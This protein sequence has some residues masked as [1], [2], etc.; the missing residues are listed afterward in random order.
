MFVRNGPQI[1]DL[2]RCSVHFLV[3]PKKSQFRLSPNHHKT[4]QIKSQNV[5][6]SDLYI[7]SNPFWHQLSQFIMTPRTLL[8]CNTSPATRSLLRLESSLKPSRNLMFYRVSLWDTLFSPVFQI[9][10]QQL[11][12]APPLGSS[13]GQN[14][15]QNRPSGANERQKGIGPPHLGRI[16][17]FTKP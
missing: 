17:V 3:S 16:H 5:F 10:A 8:F 15:A 1:S 9:D 2:F 4:S 12:L 13:S 6:C 7:C 11:D 14:G